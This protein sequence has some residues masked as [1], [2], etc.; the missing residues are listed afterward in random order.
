[1]TTVNQYAFDAITGYN[2]G[3]AADGWKEMSRADL[4]EQAEAQAEYA[5]TDTD[6]ALDPLAVASAVAKVQE[7]I[8]DGTMNQNE[9]FYIREELA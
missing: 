9:W 5:P 1:M 6:G 4:I 3:A 8:G 7:R 2:G